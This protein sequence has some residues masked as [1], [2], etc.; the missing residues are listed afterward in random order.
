[1]PSAGR[2][3]PKTMSPGSLMTP[4]HR[5]VSTMTLSTT[6]VNRPKNPFQSPGTHQ[7]M[8][9]AVSRC[10]V[11]GFL[12][13][14]RRGPMIPLRQPA[15]ARSRRGLSLRLQNRQKISRGADPSENP[16]LRLHHVQRR[17]LKLREIGGDAIFKHEA[18]VTTV[19]CFA[20]RR[21]NADFGGDAADDELFDPAAFEDGVEIGGVKSALAGLVDDRLAGCRLQLVDNVVTALP[22][23]QDAPHRAGIADRSEE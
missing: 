17:L 1:M 7:R 12:L 10:I 19:V 3:R 21:R 6:L 2:M 23:N 14:S 8:G 4:R 22:A 15:A 9:I 5:P 13:P 20:H 18:V 11:I 16:A